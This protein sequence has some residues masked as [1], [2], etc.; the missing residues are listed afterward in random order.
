MA[1]VPKSDCLGV[2]VKSRNTS[3]K[4]GILS[5]LRDL[6]ILILPLLLLPAPK[7]SVMASGSLC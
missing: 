7:P 5:F 4:G 1:L 3:Y 2:S 6:P